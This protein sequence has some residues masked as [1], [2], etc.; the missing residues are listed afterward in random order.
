M[1]KEGMYNGQ[2][3][4]K[5]KIRIDSVGD[6]METL[7]IDER[8]Q[9]NEENEIFLKGST[10][11]LRQRVMGGGYL[12]V[13]F[14]HNGV[15]NI[16]PVHR[17]VAMQRVENQDP[18]V[19]N[20]VNHK[21]GDK[22]DNFPSNLE[23]CSSSY[24]LYHSHHILGH[25]KTK[26]KV[27]PS[28]IVSIC[29]KIQG[30][31]RNKEIREVHKGLPTTFLAELRSGRTYKS[32]SKDFDMKPD[33]ASRLS[34]ARVRWVCRKLEEGMMPEAISKLSVMGIQV[35]TIE[36]IKSRDNFKAI[37]KAYKF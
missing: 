2:S 15:S 32:I 13:T 16:V 21:N 17:A 29:E 34:D 19:N 20:I 14:L 26:S 8:L 36:K 31:W 3:A 28:E 27:I 35:A 25:G 33:R 30:G 11:P 23:W 37:S 9:I 22:T 18:C 24:N 12:Y 4:S 5:T 1:N 10:E 6:N 7:L